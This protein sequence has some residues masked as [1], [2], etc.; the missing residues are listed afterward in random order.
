MDMSFSKKGFDR[1]MEGKLLAQTE[2]I[3]VPSHLQHCRIVMFFYFMSC[4]DFCLKCLIA[5]KL[6]LKTLKDKIMK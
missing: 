3:P 4:S 1:S 6:I 5:Q 2:I